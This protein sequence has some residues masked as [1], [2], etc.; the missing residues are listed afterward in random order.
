M[1]EVILDLRQLLEQ[2]H[3]SGLVLVEEA[4]ELGYHFALNSELVDYWR[5]VG[6]QLLK[7]QKVN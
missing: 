3:S 2:E 7:Y 4:L 6:N 5:H 1:L